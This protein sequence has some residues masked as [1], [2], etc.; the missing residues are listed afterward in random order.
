MKYYSKSK[1]ETISLAQQLRRD[2]PDLGLYLL[3]G[4]LGAGKTTFVKGIASTLNISE[5]DIKS[6]TFTFVNEH[7]NLIHYDLYRLEK[8]DELSL[9][10][11]QED[12]ERPGLKVIEWPEI[13]LDEI[14]TP[15]LKLSFSH[16]AEDEREI[17]VE[18]VQPK[19]A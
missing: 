13:I 6:P 5:R 7:P 4:D 16:I 8:L 10:Q 12:L 1:D 19:E 3:I 17:I 2:Y 9:A 14:K 11:I 15:H 18:L